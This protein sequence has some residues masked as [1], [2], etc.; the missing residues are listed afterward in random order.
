ML[1]CDSQYFFFFF[2]PFVIFLVQSRIDNQPNT[3]FLV[4]LSMCPGQQSSPLVPSHMTV[5]HS[6]CNNGGGRADP[7]ASSSRPEQEPLRNPS[8]LGTAIVTG[9]VSVSVAGAPGL[10]WPGSWEWP[11]VVAGGRR[12]LRGR[13]SPARGPTLVTLV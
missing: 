10:A 6:S 12:G 3:G 1:I 9:R 11:L 13:L 2:L 4:H 5:S 7:E 8:S